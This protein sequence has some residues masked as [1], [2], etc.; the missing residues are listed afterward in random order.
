MHSVES[1]FDTGHY[2]SV[3]ESLKTAVL[4]HETNL[5]Y[6]IQYDDNEYNQQSLC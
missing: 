2:N 6:L 4:Q 5:C 1:I 3:H